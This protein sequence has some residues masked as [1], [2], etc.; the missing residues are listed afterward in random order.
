MKRNFFNH[1]LNE[2]SISIMHGGE[3]P[4]LF[5]KSLT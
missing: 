5:D 1:L 2:A 4:K 3:V